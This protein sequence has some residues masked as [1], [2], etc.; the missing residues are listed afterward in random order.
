[1]KLVVRTR[2]N[3]VSKSH[4]VAKN[5]DLVDPQLLEEMVMRF[6]KDRSEYMVGWDLLEEHAEA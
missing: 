6:M 2:E 5:I 4:I 3:I 1:M